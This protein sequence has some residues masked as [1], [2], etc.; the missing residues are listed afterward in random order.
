MK[1]DR[2]EEIGG[3]N[4]TCKGNPCV[5]GVHMMPGCL[6]TVGAVM[7]QTQKQK[8]TLTH[9]TWIATITAAVTRHK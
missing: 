7:G 8:L 5:A 6:L 1:T 9:N 3:K 4:I 2:K